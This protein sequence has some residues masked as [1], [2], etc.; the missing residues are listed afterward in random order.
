MKIAFLGDS[1]TEGVP[2]ISYVDIIQNNSTG[3]EVVNL[4]KG[5]DTVSSLLRR[6]KKV[7]DLNTVDIFVL[8]IGIND[9]YGTLTWQ[10]KFLKMLK[11]QT[12]ARDNICFRKEYI[13]LLS[14]L[15]EF[16]KKVIVIPPLLIGEEI[17]NM[18]NLEV[19]A[20]V[21]I[22]KELI[23]K[24]NFDYL[25]VREVF[26]NELKNKK[27]SKYLPLRVRDVVKDVV[28][29][30]SQEMVDQRSKERGLYLTLDGVH[31]NSK[32]AKILADMITTKLIR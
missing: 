28:Q 18:W 20:L 12:A 8:F 11:N 17:G 23:D 6:L 26:I 16:N 9:V 13:K 15:E 21:E 2:G 22:I 4:G 24:T 30:K 25:D 29:L 3:F 7:K 1:I 5:G 10:Y 31:I 14:I 19:V 27:V 32:G